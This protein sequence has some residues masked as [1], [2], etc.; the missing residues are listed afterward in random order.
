MGSSLAAAMPALRDSLLGAPQD[1]TAESAW[2]SVVLLLAIAIRLNDKTATLAHY[3][4]LASLLA[5]RP[6]FVTSFDHSTIP[7]T[8]SFLYTIVAA[9]ILVNYDAYRHEPSLSYLPHY[10]LSTGPTISAA[11]NE[12]GISD[13]FR[14]LH[15]HGILSS[16][17]FSTINHIIPLQALYSKARRSRLSPDD[18][19]AL[20]NATWCCQ[21]GLYIPKPITTE[22]EEMVWMCVMQYWHVE[23]QSWVP[24]EDL[25]L[26]LARR[27]SKLDVSELLD[28]DGGKHENL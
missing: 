17:L 5:Q 11:M 25:A 24:V 18:A 15:D 1:Q 13:G 14:P 28:T 8:S 2:Y 9:V 10:V 21:T 20:L 3:R 22:F 26:A 27:L 23:R 12:R 4:G 19:A 7:F 16:F 6:D